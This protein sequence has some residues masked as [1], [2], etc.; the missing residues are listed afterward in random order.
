MRKFNLFLWNLCELEFTF[1][2]NEPIIVSLFFPVGC[3]WVAF[4]NYSLLNSICEIFRNRRA[5]N[6]C[7][8]NELNDWVLLLG[9][10][11]CSA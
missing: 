11:V 9:R 10:P 7:A 5:V 2:I 4:D 1:V 6:I 3:K 8:G